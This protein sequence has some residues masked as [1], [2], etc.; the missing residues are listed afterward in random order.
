MADWTT[1]THSGSASP[2]YST[3]F[4]SNEVN[5]FDI[6]ISEDNW[7]TMQDDLED[8]YGGGGMGQ[9]QFPDE[10]PI[11][12]PCDLFFEGKQWYNVGI[13]YKGN[14]SL[15][16]SYNTGNGKL[17]LRL[18]MDKFED[19][20]PEINNQRFYGFKEISMA[21]NFDDPSVMREKVACDVFRANGCPAPHSA[22]YEVYVDH[23]E[24]ET[25]FG[26]YTMVEVVFD[27][28][29]ADQ[30]GSE[31]GNCYK[32]DGD[33][34][35]FAEGSYGIS[36][37]EKKTNE[38]NGDWSDVEA[39]YDAIHD[40]SRTSDPAA[41]RNGLESVMDMDAMTK[42]MAVNFTIQNWDTYGKM[43]HNY[44]LYNNPNN[45]LLTWIP[46]DNN[47]AFQEGKMGGALALD[48]YDA[49]DEW[50]LLS[51]VIEDDVYE[52]MYKAHIE[53]FREN[54]FN[55]SAMS[56]RYSAEVALIEGC[57]VGSEGELPTYTFTS[58]AEF[59]SAVNELISHV[60]AREN[61]VDAYLN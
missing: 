9:G 39:L 43:T 61:V 25:Y 28:M 10:T 27:T 15:Q 42:W 22:Y 14:S 21:N 24:G 51:Y 55:S 41:W 45:G 19:D 7:A 49:T 1:A 35:S 60:A 20:Y 48:L 4:P 32:P 53:S 3:V 58:D 59:S 26:L 34:A 31:A 11:Y 2:D 46:W 38:L 44:Y 5:R 50:P 17:P 56:A 8:I 13:R 47:E 6:V 33:G 18:Q 36:Y 29:L 52:E 57:V 16:S 54:V 23:G 37:F 30:F 12:V 40:D